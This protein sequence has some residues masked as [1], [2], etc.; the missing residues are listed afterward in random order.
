MGDDMNLPPHLQ[1]VWD[2]GRIAGESGASHRENPYR[3]ETDAELHD[4]WEAAR[5]EASP[6][7][8]V[9]APAQQ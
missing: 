9:R 3:P 6:T 8:G 4:T 7:F 2:R 5:A 1:S